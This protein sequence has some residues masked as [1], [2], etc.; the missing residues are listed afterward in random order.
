[1]K[2][3][4][5][6]CPPAATSPVPVPSQKPFRPWPT[7]RTRSCA[8]SPSTAPSAGSARRYFIS[9]G[10]SASRWPSAPR[11]RRRSG[12]VVYCHRQ[13]ATIDLRPTR[14]RCNLCPRTP[15]TY[16]SG[17]HTKEES[18]LTRTTC[19][20]ATRF[21]AAL[22]MTP[23]PRSPR[24]PTSRPYPLA[25]S[26]TRTSSID[27]SPIPSH[28]HPLPITVPSGHGR[29]QA[30]PQQAV[31]GAD[32]RHSSSHSHTTQGSSSM[33]SHCPSAPHCP[34]QHGSKP[35]MRSRRCTPPHSTIPDSTRTRAGNRRWRMRKPRRCTDAACT[36]RRAC[37][38][39]RGHSGSPGRRRRRRNTRRTHNALSSR[40]GR[41]M[42]RVAR[43]RQPP[44]C[45][46]PRE[47]AGG[48]AQTRGVGSARRIDATPCESFTVRL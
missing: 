4:P 42:P 28:S 9:R 16:V 3:S 26:R 13:V 19:Q 21:L 8:R 35:R 29:R 6:P 33:N 30:P 37:Y 2:P 25:S 38:G 45:R 14:T 40:P 24:S 17:L 27:V 7:A 11:R 23:F 31:F 36:G 34:R 20:G 10:W 47:R 46:A 15:V 39:N 44:P 12:Q 32:P 48:P 18:R 43:F 1:M 22:G 41:T 5:T